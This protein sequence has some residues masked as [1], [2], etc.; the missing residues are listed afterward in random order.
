MNSADNAAAELTLPGNA[1]PKRRA[2]WLSPTTRIL[3]AMVLGI[4][5]GILLGPRVS[6]IGELGKLM[7]NLIKMLAGPLVFFAVVDAFLRTKV[8]A[9]SGL[10]M[11]AIS[12]INAT[13]AVTIGLGL[14]NLLKPG[15]LV[16][17]SF[18]ND[19]AAEFA[20]NA[21]PIKILD[22]LIALIPTNLIDPFRATSIF[23]IVILAVL[24]GM[25]LRRLK[26]EQIASGNVAYRSIEDLV[27]G[28][29]RAVEI[30]LGWIV[31]LL[32]LAVF[33]VMAQTVGTKGLGE[34]RGLAV[35]IGVV[36]LGLAIHVGLVYQGWVVLV[37]GIPLKRFWAGVREPVIY[38]AGASSS[39]ATLPVTLR[40][41]RLMGVSDEAARM[42]A[43]VGTNLN[44][45]GILLYE[46]MAALYVAQAF[47]IDLS[48]FQQ[49][50]IAATCVLAGV[51]IAGVPEAGLIS[52]ALVL[53]TAG[54]PIT[55]L[56]LLL[57]VDWILSRCRAMTN[58]ISD[59]LV[60]IL[61]DHFQSTRGPGDSTSND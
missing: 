28:S 29:L 52:L 9:R 60:A 45:D 17:L 24:G 36:V 43:C 31:G 13:L 5:A 33:A 23:S 49:L 14:S 7:I 27:A 26:D 39:L 30:L 34:L 42:S 61:I 19:A 35:Y 1:P 55:I 20:Q 46:A 38:A 15:T 41:L 18:G 25:A 53:T 32:P 11:V 4:A 48:F 16:P 54:L 2:I 6:G 57:S 8:K 50:M 21:R 22:D 59:M 40:N 51:G 37:A 10:T 44:N 3:I 58:V 47:G 12:A 56:P